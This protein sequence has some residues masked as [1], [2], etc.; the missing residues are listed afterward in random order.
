MKKERI[1]NLFGI[2]IGGAAIIVGIVMLTGHPVPSTDWTMD[3]SFGA[4]FYTYI[5]SAVR[6]AANNTAD[7]VHYIRDTL[8]L[9]GGFFFILAGLLVVLHYLKLFLAAPTKKDS[10]ALPTEKETIEAEVEI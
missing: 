2:I 7:V 8:S 5:Y 6:A 10:V 9:Y 3:A 4:D 1:L